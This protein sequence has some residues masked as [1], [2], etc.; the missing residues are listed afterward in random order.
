MKGNLK[1]MS[2]RVPAAPDAIEEKTLFIDVPYT[3]PNGTR[4]ALKH[5]AEMSSGLNGAILLI[6]A[7]VVPV[8][9]PISEPQVNGEFLERRLREIAEESVIP[10]QVEIVYTRDR[11]LAFNRSLRPNSLVVIAAGSRWWPSIEREY[12]H[13]LTRAGHDVVLVSR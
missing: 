10:V 5:A 2:T 7:V 9:R 1:T 6:D 13:F 11:L 3:T 8:Q 12:A 4:V